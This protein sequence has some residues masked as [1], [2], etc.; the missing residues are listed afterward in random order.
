MSL[1]WLLDPHPFVIKFS[2]RRSKVAIIGVFA[3]GGGGGLEPIPTAT[4]MQVLLFLFMSQVNSCIPTCYKKAFIYCYF[5]PIVTHNRYRVRMSRKQGGIYLA[6]VMK[7][8]LDVFLYICKVDM[9]V[10]WTINL[11]A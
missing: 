6:C 7:T 1:D 10:Y 3:G 2:Q 8:V 4:K 9:H 5:S 11:H